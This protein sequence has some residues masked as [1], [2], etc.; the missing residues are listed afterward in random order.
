M[1]S[2]ARNFRDTL[3]KSSN[4]SAFTPSFLRKQ[5]PKTLWKEVPAFAETTGRDKHPG[6]GLIQRF[7][8]QLQEWLGSRSPWARELTLGEG[9]NGANK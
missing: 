3:N 7:L 1:Q 6:H 5:E 8:S 9:A 2:D 4:A